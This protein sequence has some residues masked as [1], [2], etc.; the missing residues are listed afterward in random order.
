VCYPPCVLSSC[1]LCVYCV[2]VVLFLSSCV[3]GVFCLA[4][5]PSV[6][7]CPCCVLVFLCFVSC[8][9]IVSVFVVFFVLCLMCC[10][11]VCV[12]CVCLVCCSPWVCC[13]CACYSYVSIVCLCILSACIYMCLPVCALLYVCILCGCVCSSLCSVC[14][15]CTV[16]LRV[17]RLLW[18]LSWWCDGRL[19]FGFGGLCFL[20]GV[21]CWKIFVIFIRVLC[22]GS[23][24]ISPLL[25]VFFLIAV[26]GVVFRSEFCRRYNTLKLCLC[27]TFVIAGKG[28]KYG[29]R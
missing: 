19:F 1:S 4:F 5:V 28:F 16:V 3:V 2:S 23:S 7:L 20:V 9:S 8:V 6:P 10:S 12:C 27:H 22:W 14:V 17:T 21:A 25:W 29:C 24:F 11:P 15:L 13:L 18:R 26:L